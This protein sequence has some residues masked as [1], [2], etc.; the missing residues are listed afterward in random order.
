LSLSYREFPSSPFAT[1]SWSLT[2][3]RFEK[4]EQFVDVLFSAYPAWN[5]GAAAVFL[6]H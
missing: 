4:S 2:A 1:L 6:K 5:E 3:S